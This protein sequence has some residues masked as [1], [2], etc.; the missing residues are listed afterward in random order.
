MVQ[1]LLQWMPDSSASKSSSTKMR[2]RQRH[3]NA[4]DCDAA[5]CLDARFI[6]GLSDGSAVSTWSDRSRNAANAT[7]TGANRPEYK[8]AIQGGQP[9]VRFD[10]TDDFF[11]M[12]TPLAAVFQNKSYG[13]VIATAKDRNPTAAPQTHMVFWSDNSQNLGFARYSLV[14]KILNLNRFDSRS[15][16]LDAD[17]ISAASLSPNDSNWHILASEQEWSNNTNRLRIEFT[18]RATATYSSGGGSTSNT[19]S[20]SVSI[21]SITGFVANNAAPIDLAQ[22]VVLNTATTESLVKRLHHAAAFSFK[23]ACN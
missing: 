11:P 6:T 23:I 3:F 10:G 18:S 13:I 1:I 20:A 5:L 15:R 17:S 19:A 9:V 21:G 7:Q 22:L 12:T 2:A 8:E 4:R 14:T 16:R